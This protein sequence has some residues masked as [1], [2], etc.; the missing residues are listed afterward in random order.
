[1][2]LPPLHGLLDDHELGIHEMKDAVY[3]QREGDLD[4]HYRIA[5]AS[6]NQLLLKLLGSE[7]YQLLRMSRTSSARSPGRP[8]EALHEHR[9]IVMAI[10]QRRW[11]ICRTVD[12]Q[13]H[14]WGVEDC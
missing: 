5:A 11:R 14:Q 9:Q 10:Q 2:R 1:M 3:L 4:F 12:A 7:L 13:A 8:L 6:N